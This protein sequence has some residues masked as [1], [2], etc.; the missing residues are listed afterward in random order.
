MI[1][2]WSVH[3]FQ[4]SNA[5]TDVRID[6]SISIRYMATEFGKQVHLGDLTQMTLVKQISVTLSH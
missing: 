2:G 3:L 5:R 6:I 1:R 4:G